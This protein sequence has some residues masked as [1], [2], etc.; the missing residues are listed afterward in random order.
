MDILDHI[1][2]RALVD[3]GVCDD[4]GSPGTESL[5]RSYNQYQPQWTRNDMIRKKTDKWNIIRVWEEEYSITPNNRRKNLFLEVIL[6][7][8]C[9][10]SVF[11]TER[12]WKRSEAHQVPFHEIWTHS[13]DSTLWRQTHWSGL[14]QRIYVEWT[15]R[16]GKS[17][18]LLPSLHQINVLYRRRGFKIKFLL[19]D[20]QFEP[21]R[22]K[23]TG[24]GM[25]VDTVAREVHVP[26]V[27]RLHCS[28]EDKV[29]SAKA[30]M[31]FSRL[32]KMMVNNFACWFCY[33]LAQC[34]PTADRS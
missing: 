29:R 33:F 4:R 22:P 28:V 26:E 1:L 23:A 11:I 10:L 12:H 27:E 6:C 2:K 8:R 13:S 20:G 17:T 16:T 14:K 19:V 32:M 7:V 15:S 5:T 30:I 25:N 31:P 3:I 9:S 18:L 21:L 34:L 24:M